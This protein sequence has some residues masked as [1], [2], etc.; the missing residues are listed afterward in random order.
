MHQWQS[1]PIVDVFGVGWVK[2]MERLLV[3]WLFERS[4]IGQGG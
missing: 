4:L 2:G 3:Q 1:T